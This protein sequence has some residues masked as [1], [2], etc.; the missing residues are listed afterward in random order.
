MTPPVVVHA[1]RLRADPSRVVAQLFL[2]GEGVASTHSR[3]AQIVERVLA[4]H[5]ETVRTLARDLLADFGP[6]HLDT[7]DLLRANAG[8]VGSRVQTTK[9]LTEDQSIVLGATFT[10]EYAVEAA[11]LCNPSAVEHPDQSGLLPGQLRVAVALR[12]IGE[13]HISSIEFTEAI[14][15]PG[16]AWAFAPRHGPVA[17][18]T[19]LPARW[20]STH[21]RMAL[22]HE[23]Q[24]NELTSWVLDRL[25]SVFSGV[26]VEAAIAALPPELLHHRDSGTALNALRDMVSSAYIARFDP[27][28]D[29]SQRVL[30]PAAVEEHNGMEDARLVRFTADD[31]STAYRATY[32]AY[33][34]RDIAP[35]L[36]TTPDLVSFAI[37]RLSGPSAR[38][39]GMALFPRTVNGRHFALA[40]TDGESISLAS[41]PDG[42]IWSGETLLN[43][44]TEPWEM[45][46]TGNCGSPIETDR[47]WLVLTHGVGPFRVYSISAILLDLDDPSVVL[48]RARRPILQPEG[49]D[50]EGYVPNVVYSCGGIVHDGRLWVPIGIGDAQVGV[51]STDLGALLDSMRLTTSAEDSVRIP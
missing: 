49:A 51:F 27:T 35:R 10:A 20:H 33:D 3:A 30:L 23:D 40:R 21:L 43:V 12:A 50:R 5:P 4:L 14:I 44:P 47:G 7:A 48:A 45:V 37:H 41:S 9:P 24:V 28:T 15:G 38:N 11:A 19:I 8:A 34:G 13:G 25:P 31:G 17:T 36:I 2:P 46:Q 32:T 22:E 1:D 18:A 26:D 39:K 42:F 16:D 6:R 29:L